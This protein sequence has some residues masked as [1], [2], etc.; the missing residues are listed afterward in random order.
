VADP[1]IVPENLHCTSSTDDESRCEVLFF[2]EALDLAVAQH[3][4]LLGAGTRMRWT[5]KDAVI[6]EAVP[7]CGSVTTTIVGKA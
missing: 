7:V 2:C 3:A 4:I 1:L 5:R 6:V